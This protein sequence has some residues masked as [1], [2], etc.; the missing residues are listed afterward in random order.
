[1]FENLNPTQ[2]TPKPGQTPYLDAIKL[3]ARRDYSRIKLKKK[4]LSKGHPAEAVEATLTTL[5]EEGYLNEKAYIDARIRG[6]MHKGWAPIHIQKK[7]AAEDLDVSQQFIE[8]IFER[9][10]TTQEEQIQWILAKKTPSELPSAQDREGWE[11]LK[12]RL[13]RNL[14]NKGH[15]PQMCIEAVTS[16]IDRLQETNGH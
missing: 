5:E 3:L 13:M 4:L 9:E 2:A 15:S 14:A 6:F 11:K 10:K 16:L 7:L 1:M 12:N 8:Q